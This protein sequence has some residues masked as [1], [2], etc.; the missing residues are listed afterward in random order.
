MDFSK[1]RSYFLLP[2]GRVIRPSGKES[3]VLS[4]RLTSVF[5]CKAPSNDPDWHGWDELFIRERQAD[6]PDRAYQEQR[7][8]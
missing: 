7:G 8:R 5:L 6:G 1:G 2:L 4:P 3:E